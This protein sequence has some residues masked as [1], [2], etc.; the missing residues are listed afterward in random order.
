VPAQNPQLTVLVSIDEPPA[1]GPHFGGLVAAPV[2]SGI[3]QAA[4]QEFQIPPVAGTTTCP[5]SP[6]G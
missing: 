4:L 6:A 1:N 2:F 3:A 5:Q